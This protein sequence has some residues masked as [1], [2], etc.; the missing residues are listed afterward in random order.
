MAGSASPRGKEKEMYSMGTV[1]LIYFCLLL[2]SRIVLSVLL[3][4]FVLF[5]FG[6]EKAGARAGQGAVFGCS[7][8]H[9]CIH[10]IVMAVKRCNAGSMNGVVVWEGGSRLAVS[11]VQCSAVHCSNHGPG[12][13]PRYKGCCHSEHSGTRGSKDVVPVPVPVQQSCT[14]PRPRSE[15]ALALCS[16]D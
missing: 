8:I 2:S 7:G 12:S 10:L 11:S 4:C 5:S 16:I 6:A 14:I 1:C 13:D 9:P 3:L 15:K